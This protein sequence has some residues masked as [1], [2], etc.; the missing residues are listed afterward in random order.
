MRRGEACGEDNN[1]PRVEPD[2]TKKWFHPLGLGCG[3]KKS[4]SPRLKEKEIPG[5]KK[6]HWMGVEVM[7]K[8]ESEV[9][10]WIKHHFCW[11]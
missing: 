4:L 5:A 6:G 8:G 3:T 9:K 2:L 1:A 7:L 11:E 10:D